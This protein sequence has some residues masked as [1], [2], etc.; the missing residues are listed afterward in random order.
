VLV[1]TCAFK[2]LLKLDSLFLGG[3]SS[4]TCYVCI[5]GTYSGL[6]QSSCSICYSGTYSTK[7]GATSSAECRIVLKIFQFEAPYQLTE[8]TENIKN[9][10][11]LAVSNV[12]GVPAYNVVLTFVTY[13]G[14][15]SRRQQTVLRVSVG[16]IDFQGSAAS[17]ASKVTQQKFDFEMGALGLKSGQVTPM[18]GIFH[19][20]RV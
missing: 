15:T 10:M 6:G 14:Y 18:T 19:E 3:T 8:V 20:L 16:I 2:T 12:L 13:M 9:R 1:F 7:T 4:S 5:P 17:Y 11:S